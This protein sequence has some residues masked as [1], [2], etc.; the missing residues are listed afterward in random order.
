MR[1]RPFIKDGNKYSEV[2]SKFK[3]PDKAQK[4]D[5]E[6]RKNANRSLKKGYRQ[7]LK[8]ETDQLLSNFLNKKN[9][10]NIDY[11]KVVE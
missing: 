8:R 3:L 2:R 4:S 5:K 6:E 11:G 10:N 9:K 7:E 1:I